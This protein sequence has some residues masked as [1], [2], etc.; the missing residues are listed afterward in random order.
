[1]TEATRAEHVE[2]AKRRAL[3]YVDLG[4]LDDAWASL[5]SDLQNHP[6]TRDHSGI[7]LGMRLLIAEKLSTAGEM[8][9]FIEDF[10]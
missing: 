5:V 8:R 6:Q 2:W 4:L 10:Q 3:E 7:G 1:M 9:K